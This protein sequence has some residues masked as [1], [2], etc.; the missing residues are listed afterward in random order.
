MGRV[1]LLGGRRYEV[2]RKRAIPP[3]LISSQEVSMQS[4]MVIRDKQ[5]KY[6]K[7]EIEADPSLK[8]KLKFKGKSAHFD[9][10]GMTPA[11][12]EV[13]KYVA[14]VRTIAEINAGRDER[15]GLERFKVF[16]GQCIHNARITMEQ[17]G[18]LLMM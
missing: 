17:A 6:T 4:A 16:T 3:L 15:E 1:G 18:C 7:A 14:A 8:G 9:V 10:P 12:T 2:E 5:V 11:Q 13:T